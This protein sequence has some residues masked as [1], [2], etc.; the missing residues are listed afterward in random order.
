MFG[1]LL[2]GRPITSIYTEEYTILCR[3][4]MQH[5][6]QTRYYLCLVPGRGNRVRAITNAVILNQFGL[7]DLATFQI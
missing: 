2:V 4:D 1:R 5:H 6:G 3:P 7:Y